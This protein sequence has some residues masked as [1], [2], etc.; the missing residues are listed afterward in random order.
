MATTAKRITSKPRNGTAVKHARFRSES[1][2]AARERAA[3]RGAEP[4][5]PSAGAGAP[6]KDKH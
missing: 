5:T 4:E 6:A 3:Q 1:E 2:S